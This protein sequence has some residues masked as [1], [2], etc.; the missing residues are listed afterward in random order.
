M[1]ALVNEEIRAAD[2]I[3][4][5]ARPEAGA[6]VTFEG[7][8]RNHA[9]GKN[10]TSLEYHAYRPMALRKLE[11]IERYALDRFPILD[12]ALI[13]RLGPLAIGETSVLVVVVSEHRDAAFRASRYCIDTLK[14]T[15][16]IW[17]KEYGEEG[18]YWI[19]GDREAGG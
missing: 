12:V 9:H 15:V 8:V 6:V 2:W 18:E 16:P 17:K 5:I 14:E 13:H 10:V 4:K 11:E 19:E 7:V 1:I 3:A